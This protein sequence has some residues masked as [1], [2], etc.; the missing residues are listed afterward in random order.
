MAVRELLIVIIVSPEVLV[1]QEAIYKNV[2]HILQVIIG[3][4][5]KDVVMVVIY[6]AIL[7]IAN[8]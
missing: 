1:A 3:L 2:F 6:R 4:I 8:A 7:L 5:L